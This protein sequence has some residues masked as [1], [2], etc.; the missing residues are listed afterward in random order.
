MTG[1]PGGGSTRA[2][3]VAL[4]LEPKAASTDVQS[5][6]RWQRVLSLLATDL[7]PQ[8]PPV[9]A[10]DRL[11]DRLPPVSGAPDFTTIV[12]AIGGPW[13]PLCPGVARRVLHRDDKGQALALLLRADP[14]AKLY[15]H[16]H[17]HREECVV[18]SGDVQVA[19]ADLGPGDFHAADAGTEHGVMATRGGMLVFI[20]IIPDIAAA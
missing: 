17:P 6:S 3:L 12:A 16:P 18:I 10:W 1:R 7:P 20:R 19:G 8:P 2:G 9:G 5:V 13:E 15:P 4:G 11:S 14:G